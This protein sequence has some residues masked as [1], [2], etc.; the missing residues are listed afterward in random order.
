MPL[1]ILSAFSGCHSDFTF[2]L[3]LPFRTISLSFSHAS[4]L[5]FSKDSDALFDKKDDNQ[6]Y[7][8]MHQMLEGM[9]Y[10]HFEKVIHRDIKPGML[11]TLSFLYPNYSSLSLS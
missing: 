1:C 3:S 8:W 9:S 7:I 6:K 11:A 5:Y 10:V 2:I 4:E